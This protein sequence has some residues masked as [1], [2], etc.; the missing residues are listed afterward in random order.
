MTRTPGPTLDPAVLTSLRTA[1]DDDDLV[2]EIIKAFLSDTPGQLASL[3][4][5]DQRGDLPTVVA[6]AHLI[7]GSALTFGAVRL[8]QLC[9][10]LETAPR[11][12]ARVL[13]VAGEFEELRESLSAYLE[14]LRGR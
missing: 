12:T 2:A 13:A 1:M 14:E 11:D 6:Q 7:K 4:A 5:A 9:A 8:V 3:V 10:A